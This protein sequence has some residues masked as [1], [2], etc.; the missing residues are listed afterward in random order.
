MREVTDVVDND[1]VKLGVF[2]K[3]AFALLM[4]VMTEF[5][6]T[7]TTENKEPALLSTDVP[8]PR[9]RWLILLLSFPTFFSVKLR[10]WNSFRLLG[11]SASSSEGAKLTLEDEAFDPADSKDVA[12]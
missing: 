8:P 10:D 7:D 11:C 3:E 12:R 4:V 1:L 2:R 9:L 6:F 5:F